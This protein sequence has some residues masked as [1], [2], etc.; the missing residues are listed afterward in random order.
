V[1]TARVKDIGE[2]PALPKEAESPVAPRAPTTDA[3][4]NVV[5]V[6]FPWAE[7]YVDGNRLGVSPPLRS[8]ALRPGKH[9]VELRNSSFPAHVETVD[10]KSGAEISVK[11]RFS[12]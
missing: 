2:M 12:R 3:A 11:H 7:V 5:I 6:A 1:Q 8:I 4:I 10:V 9:K